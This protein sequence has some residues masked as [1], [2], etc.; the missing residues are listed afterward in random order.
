MAT[1]E[2][3]TARHAVKPPTSYYRCEGIAEE[4]RKAEAREAGQVEPDAPTAGPAAPAADEGQERGR[5]R[6]RGGPTGRIHWCGAGPIGR[7]QT[8]SADVRRGPRRP[9]HGG[10]PRPRQTE[11]GPGGP[12]SPRRPPLGR[13]RIESLE[14]KTD[15]S[16]GGVSTRGFRNLS[17]YLVFSTLH[18]VSSSSKSGHGTMAAGRC[19]EGVRSRWS[20]GPGGRCAPTTPDPFNPVTSH[21]QPCLSTAMP[22]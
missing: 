1:N 15:D 6:L 19:H 20:E 8:R 17:T 9:A 21:R 4:F 18:S 2:G 22:T 3:C 10:P 12:R 11:P 7:G 13:R 16:L 14:G 5:I